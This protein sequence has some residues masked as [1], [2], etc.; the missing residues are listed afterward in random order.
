MDSDGASFE[1]RIWSHKWR[2]SGGWISNSGVRVTDYHVSTSLWG[3]SGD[4]IGRVGVVAHGTFYLL[5]RWIIFV[6][7]VVPRSIELL[8]AG[9][10]LLEIGHFLKL[11]DLYDTDNS[12]YGLGY[13]CMMA[14]SWGYE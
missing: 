3:T 1:D 13:F 12:G 10:P 4:D 5:T 14:N 8:T 9:F 2:I 7:S 6:M 11:P